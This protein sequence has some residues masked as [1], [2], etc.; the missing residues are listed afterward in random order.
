MTLNRTI[1]VL[2][3]SAATTVFVAAVPTILY[4]VVV[5]RSV[6]ANGDF[7]GPLNVVLIPLAGLLIGAVC[8]LLFASL[9]AMFRFSRRCLIVMPPATAIFILVISLFAR[10]HAASNS[11]V[12]R[13]VAVAVAAWLGAAAYVFTLAFAGLSR[14]LRNRRNSAA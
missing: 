1:V 7:G 4:A 3:S 6:I 2:L 9:A 13:Y 10:S 11:T 5:G 14:L 8:S 12:D